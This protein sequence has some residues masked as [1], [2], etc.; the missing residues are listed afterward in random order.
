MAVGGGE[1]RG[2]CGAARDGEAG[3]R[4]G[5]PGDPGQGAVR[6]GVRSKVAGTL[7][8]HGGT[9]ALKAFLPELKCVEG[10]VQMLQVILK[11]PSLEKA[12]E[13]HDSPEYQAIVPARLETT[14]T[15]KSTFYIAEGM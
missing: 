7:G 13:W 5:E 14:D 1:G 9:Y 11:F 6:G 15:E 8:P 10:P 4:G 2:A 12:V 3:V